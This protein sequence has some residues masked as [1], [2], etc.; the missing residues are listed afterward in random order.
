MACMFTMMNRARL[1]IGAQGVGIAEAATQQAAA[2]AHERRQGHGPHMDAAQM[3]AIVEHVDVKRMLLTMRALTNAARAICYTTA[4][5]IDR[6]EREPDPAA[7]ASA[8]ERASLLTPVAKAFSTDVATDVASL[9]VQIHG[10]MGFIEET[11]AA[12]LYRDARITQIYEGTNGI[13]AIDLVARKLPMSGGA[14]VRGYIG[15]LRDTIE[16]VRAANDPAFGMT[17]T[18]LNEA[19]DQLARATEW[20]LTT[21][22]GD[23][24][25][26]LAGATPYLRLFGLA[27]GGCMLAADAMAALRAGDGAVSAPR[28]IATAKFFATNLTTAAGGLATTVVEGADGFQ[29]IPAEQIG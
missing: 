25:R 5:A 17:A 18:R 20:L 8:H 11:G 6:S 26:A 15:E 1:A 28:M 29:D 19:V 13:Q 9:D 16:A 27:A 2:Y 24:D 10:G 7:R 12:Q 23:P 3:S 22:V 21:Q 14:T 4:V